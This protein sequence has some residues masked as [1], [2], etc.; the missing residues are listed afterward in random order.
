MSPTHGHMVILAGCVAGF[1]ETAFGLRETISMHSQIQPSFKLVC[2]P[3]QKW[4]MGDPQRPW[5][6]HN[7]TPPSLLLL[8]RTRQ[9]SCHTFVTIKHL[10]DTRH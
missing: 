8:Q 5:K 6:W 2:E 9:E 10:H 3:S 7:M 1:A 4:D